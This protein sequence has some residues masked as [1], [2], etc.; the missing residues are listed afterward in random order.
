MT[1]TQAV[2]DPF[3]VE[4]ERVVRRLRALTPGD[5]AGPGGTWRSLV[6]SL[7]QEL[8]DAHADAVGVGRRDVVAAGGDEVTPALLAEMLRAVSFDAGQVT[9]IQG[10]APGLAAVRRAL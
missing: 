2:N 7:I 8:A 4:L 1:D 9:D 6:L 10:F 3:E 5:D